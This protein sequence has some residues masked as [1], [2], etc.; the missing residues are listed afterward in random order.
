MIENLGPINPSVLVS[1]HKTYPSF[2]IHMDRTISSDTLLQTPHHPLVVM[3]WA[4]N[5]TVLRYVREA[6]LYSIHQVG[7]IP[8]DWGMI[9]ALVEW[10]TPETHTFHLSIGEATI[11]LLDVAILTDLPVSGRA[12]TGPSPSHMKEQTH[13][14]LGVPPPDEAM[15]GSSVK[16]TWMFNTFCHFPSPDA[17]DAAM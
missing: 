15:I 13:R 5:N 2:T 8:S 17:K 6:G 7:Q 12:V 4:V 1:Q 3:R 14:M 9:T 16:A 11:T 10:C